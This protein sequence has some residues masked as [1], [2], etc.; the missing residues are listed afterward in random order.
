MEAL[1]DGTKELVAVWDGMRESKASWLEV[2][3]DLKTRGL[4]EAPKLAVGDGAL[5]I[6]GGFGGRVFQSTRA[7]VLGS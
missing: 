5:G 7:T 3:R 1:E 6:L 2:L 4:G